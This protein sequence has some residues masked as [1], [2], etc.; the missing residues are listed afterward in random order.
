[1]SLIFKLLLSLSL[2]GEGRREGKL[3]FMG[4][5]SQILPFSSLTLYVGIR[6]LVIRLDPAGRFVTSAYSMVEKLVLRGRSKTR[7][8]ALVPGMSSIF[9]VYFVRISA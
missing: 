7:G 1:M 4:P 3:P 9:I 8:L 5:I 6:G 2:G